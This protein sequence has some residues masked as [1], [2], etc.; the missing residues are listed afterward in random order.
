MDGEEGLEA[1]VRPAGALTIDGDTSYLTF[2]K[3]PIA[4]GSSDIPSVLRV[5]RQPV[6]VKGLGITL[7]SPRLTST[8]AETQEGTTSRQPI[9]REEPVEL[10]VKLLTKKPGDEDF[11]EVTD[12][13]TQRPKVTLQRNSIQLDLTHDRTHL[14]TTFFPHFV[15]S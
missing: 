15:L 8:P 5:F 12:P 11:T 7:R 1:E 9:P 3:L 13:S 6:A 2:T 10:T 14:H 4:A